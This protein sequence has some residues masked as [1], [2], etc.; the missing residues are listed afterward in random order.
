MVRH[1]GGGA[2]LSGV[3]SQFCPWWGDL[4]ASLSVECDINNTCL[5]AFVKINEQIHEII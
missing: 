1:V 5:L 2:R 4:L 3:Q